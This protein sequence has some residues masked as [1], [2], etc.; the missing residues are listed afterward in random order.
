MGSSQPNTV[1]R[2]RAGAACTKVVG[3]FAGERASMRSTRPAVPR[4]QWISAG[5]LAT[6]GFVEIATGVLTRQGPR[7]G[8]IGSTC[9]CAVIRPG[10]AAPAVSEVSA[11]GF[12][13][14]RPR[15]IVIRPSRQRHGDCVHA[16]CVGAHL[17]QA[18]EKPGSTGVYIFSFLFSVF[19]FK[20][21]VSNQS[22]NSTKV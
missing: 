4:G 16:R 20:I 2:P 19:Y 14:H 21:L 6:A 1:S 12:M 11:V 3:L 13:S 8:V 17:G 10:G 7:A 15:G 22:S 9:E 18:G 5:E